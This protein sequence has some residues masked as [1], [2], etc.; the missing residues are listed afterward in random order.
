MGTGRLLLLLFGVELRCIVV[1]EPV[2]FVPRFIVLCLASS[3]IVYQDMKEISIIRL[4]R[5]S[6][7]SGLIFSLDFS[8]DGDEAAT[9]KRTQAI[10]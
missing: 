5:H 1:D 9:R 3:R 8:G 10:G 2:P 4:V 7:Q 6:Q